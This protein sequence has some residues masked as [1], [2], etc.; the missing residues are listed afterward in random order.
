MNTTWETHK[1]EHYIFS[2]LL[3]AE[4]I[5]SFTFL[6]YVH[7]P[8]ISITTAYIP[9][10]ITACLFGPAEASLAGLLFGLGSLYKASATYVM[11]ADAVFSPFRSD[12]PIGSILLSVGTRVLFGFLL[13]CLFQLA[14]KSKRKNL[15]KLLITIAAPKLHALL[16]Y[17]AMGLFF[18]SLGFNFSSTFILE[19]ATSL[20]CCSVLRSF[21]GLTSCITVPLSR[22]I[23]N[24][25]NEYENTP[26]W[27]PKIGFVL[28][29]VSTF[30]FCMAVLSTVYF[31]NRMYY[32]LGQHG[33]DVTLDIHRDILHLQVQFLT[34]MLALNFILLILILMVYRYMKFREY[35]GELDFLT[36]IMGRKL[37][38][39]TCLRSQKSHAGTAG[40]F[41]VCDLDYFKH[42][43]DKYGHSVGD[44]V[45]KQFAEH[46][47]NTFRF[48]GSVGRIGGD[49]FAVMLDINLSPD[50]LEH[51]LTQFLRDISGIL[52]QVTVSCS[53]GAYRFI[54]PQEIKHL[55]TET[56][57]V[58][59][60]AKENGRACFV[61]EDS[62]EK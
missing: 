9:I 25:V 20:S 21:W 51:L 31:S 19:K 42:I 11:P 44:E 48:C 2:L 49:E 13:G 34:A 40:W 8:P 61:I 53:I 23:K 47:Q 33:I 26:Y 7:I 28:G 12:F 35:T 4:V 5:M 50:Q 16:V 54:F 22:P 46:L 58:L 18:P 14:R 41:L 37:F 15:C 3:A 38:L 52:E 39:H 10:I 45:L 56:D 30:I 29:G 24:A 60:Q 32:M 43:N 62:T 6:G 57:R 36:G 17:T 1:F 59:Y 27:S 55:L